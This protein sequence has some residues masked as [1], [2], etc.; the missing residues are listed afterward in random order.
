MSDS[1]WPHGL[2]F[3]RLL[4]PWNSSSKNTG[5]GSHSL[6]QGIFLTQGLNPGVDSLPSEPPGKP[7]VWMYIFKPDMLKPNT[8]GDGIRR[9]GPLEAITS[10]LITALT[11]GISAL[12]KGALKSSLGPPP[13]SWAYN[14]K[15]P[16]ETQKRAF[17]WP[18]W[19]PDRGLPAP[20]TVRHK[21][22]LLTS[23][24]VND[25]FVIAAQTD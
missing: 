19:H 2:W 13:P 3:A 23:Q 15:S 25:I 4:C 8:Q 16:F 9:W 7:M 18:C 1:L 21:F 6:L 12:R 5:R 22:L 14:E 20:R 11:N 10:R 17:T 24:P